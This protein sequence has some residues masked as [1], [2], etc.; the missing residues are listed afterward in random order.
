[1]YYQ[2]YLDV[3]AQGQSYL[4]MFVRD[5][6][7]FIKELDAV[8]TLDAFA[9]EWT[10]IPP[11]TFSRLTPGTRVYMK[12]KYEFRELVVTTVPVWREDEEVFIVEARPSEDPP[13]AGTD[14]ILFGVGDVYI[15]DQ[16]SEHST[17]QYRFAHSKALS[18]GGVK[19]CP[20]RL[21]T[22]RIKGQ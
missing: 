6:Y 9:Q 15:C 1:M 5:Y 21:I 19:S 8:I 4:D 16:I 12:A 3:V 14:V 10:A 11:A 2:C 13:D 22:T 17:T 18:E 20:I 7:Q